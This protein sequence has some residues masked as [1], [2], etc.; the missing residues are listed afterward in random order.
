M[1]SLW[2]KTKHYQGDLQAEKAWMSELA[3]FTQAMVRGSAAGTPHE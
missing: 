1:L 2:A 3:V